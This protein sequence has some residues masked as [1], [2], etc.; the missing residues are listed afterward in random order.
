MERGMS[1]TLRIDGFP[2]PLALPRLTGARVEAV[3]IELYLPNGITRAGWLTVPG[4]GLG[5][6]ATADPERIHWAW[7]LWPWPRSFLGR[8]AC[9]WERRAWRDA[10]GG[11][12]EWCLHPPSPSEA[13]A[14]T[15]VGG[16]SARAYRVDRHEGAGARSV[17]ELHPTTMT[18]ARWAWH[19]EEPASGS[20]WSV[21]WG[22]RG[23]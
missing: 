12:V 8:M 17:A 22:F 6:L 10:W 4:D 13:R 16:G 23:A 21:I 2:T 3:G 19:S 1:S 14:V 20:P 18:R 15:P 9:V 5:P 11:E 7:E